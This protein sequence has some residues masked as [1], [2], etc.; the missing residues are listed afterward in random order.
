MTTLQ[1][2]VIDQLILYGAIITTFIILTIAVWLI[3]KPRKRKRKI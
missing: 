1:P 3:T 2:P